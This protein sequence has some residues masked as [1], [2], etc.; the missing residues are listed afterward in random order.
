MTDTGQTVQ[1]DALT[2]ALTLLLERE[3]F[4]FTTLWDSLSANQKTL[5]T[6]I[7]VSTS[8][9][10]P[11]GSG[12]VR[13]SGMRTASNVQRAVESLSQRDLIDRNGKGDLYIPDRFLKLWIQRRIATSN[14]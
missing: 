13:Q 8:N 11:F 4:A 2:R 1:E 3:T 10:Q 12:F 14:Q 6:A 5:L 7:A 9:I